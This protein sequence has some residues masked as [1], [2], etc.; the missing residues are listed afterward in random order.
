MKNLKIFYF[1]L[2]ASLLLSCENNVLDKK[3][4]DEINEE[5]VWTDVTLA[6]LYLN[7]CYL[8]LF[9][10]LNEQR[11]LDT[12]TEIGDEGHEWGNSQ[13][14]NEGDVSP[15]SNS[16]DD[17][18]GPNQWERAYTQIRK[19]NLLLKNSSKMQGEQEAIDLL[20]GQTYFLRGY[21]YSEL[22][23]LY[24][25][26]PIIDQVQEL[27]DDLSVTRNTYEE[28][29]EFII[30][31]F[32]KAAEL[33][34]LAWD[35]SQVGRATRGAALAYKA[36]LLL[37][38]A[39]PLHNPSGTDEKWQL[40]SD[41]AKAV[42]DLGEYELYPDYYETFHVENNQEIIFDIQ[43]AFPMRNMEIEF[44]TNPQGFQGSYGMTRPTQNMV[45]Y[46]E[47]DNGL[48]ITDL[49]SGYDDQDPY[50]NRDPRFYA[51]ILY[52]GAPWRDQIIETFEDGL[53]GPG[54]QDEYSTSTQMT[55]YYLR[56]FIHKKNPLIASNPPTPTN[57][58]LMRLAEVYLNYAE[59]QLEL[60]N[61]GEARTYIN[62]VRE[63][64]GMPEIPIEETGEELKARYRNE[65]VVELAF[66][67]IHF[68]DVR[69]WEIAPDVL[70]Q[71][72]NK[73]S[74]V[75]NDDDTFTYTVEEMEERVWKDEFYFFPIP[76]DDIDR[77]KNLEQN[78]GY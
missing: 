59:A 27:T 78:P 46:Y 66:E 42:I 68:F 75:K 12:S 65:R 57:W 71:P 14:W 51:S 18:D 63:R 29:V 70:S 48:S 32:D 34:P 4:L 67:E 10:G 3:P 19:L 28:C 17:D 26:V 21:F 2:I 58:V 39:S 23:N 31:D 47:M 50:A 54:E 6:N 52:N 13:R 38:A 7:D 55:G 49:S 40:A 76:G 44:R 61:E 43:Y 74:I 53:S 30:S 11:G 24:N 16:Y 41:A 72:V 1:S 35:Q 5:L 60:G 45:D 56:K 36:R 25:G 22:V 77:N 73:V 33:L 8:N 37:F 64:A 9:G 20:I 62:L 15:Y 69:R